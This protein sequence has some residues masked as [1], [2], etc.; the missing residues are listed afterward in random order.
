MGPLAGL[1]VV[2]IFGMGPGPFCGMM[3]SDMGA[4][5]LRVDKPSDVGILRYDLGA[6]EG[7][8]PQFVNHRG[9]RS[10]AVDLKRA[11][12]AETVLRLVER[13][14][15]LFEGYRPGVC[16]RL[17]IGPDDCLARN[18][19]LVYGRMTGWGQDGP[20]KMV[21]GHD[22]DY[23]A[24]SGM[25]AAI[26]PAGG[27]P[28]VPLTLLGDMAG[29]LFLAFG[30]ACALL[31]ARRSG[32][33]QVV[34]A[35]MLDGAALLGS[36]FYGLRQLGQW[37]IERGANAFDGG[38]P[39]YSTYEAAD[40]EW[41]A[42]GAIEAKF[43]AALL[44][45]LGIAADEIGEQWDRDSWPATRRRFEAQFRTRPRD[46]WVARFKNLDAC[47]APVLTMDEA[48][49]HDHNRGRGLFVEH[50][51]VKQPA[52]APR[53]SRTEARIAGPAAMA[54]EH[55]EEALADWGFDASEIAA[56]Q[57]RDVIVGLDREAAGLSGS[58]HVQEIE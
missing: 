46:E 20:W 18:P 25:L 17:G 57:E 47:F 43:F 10:I 41:V 39:F 5:V 33:G 4:D 24:L 13:A 29:G 15:A 38:A 9:R 42:V 55:T 35:A 58:A 37:N 44:Q 1:R 12:G 7:R 52:P 36:M 16:E 26:G 2:E 30:I 56:L 32:K 28:T 49:G 48:L 22:I 54:G 31:E 19:R 40:G 23:L 50:D 3:L 14:D 21:A 34:D 51:G 45:G 8:E 53:F 11:E 27:P 6:I